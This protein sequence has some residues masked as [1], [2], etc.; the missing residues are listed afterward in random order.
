MLYMHFSNDTQVVEPMKKLLNFMVPHIQPNATV[1]EMAGI[2][3]N[4][5]LS[6]LGLSLLQSTA[7]KRKI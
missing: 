2:C 4:P 5:Y 6:R 3:Q 1:S 7:C